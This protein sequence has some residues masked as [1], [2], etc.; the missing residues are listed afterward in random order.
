[1]S[2]ESL[3]LYTPRVNE[4][5]ELVSLDKI[6]LGGLWTLDNY[7]RELQSPNSHFLVLSTNSVGAIIGCGCFWRILEEAHITLLMINPSYQSQGLG[8]LLLYSLLKNAV[9]SH[10]EH[11][12]LEVR[13]S[14]KS[15]IGLYEKFG[16]KIA[17]R[18]KKYYKKT[19]EDALIFWKSDLNSP[20]FQQELSSWKKLIN[21]RLINS[22]YLPPDL[23]CY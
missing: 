6:C 15:A 7:E 12:T 22:C 5:D 1:M 8:Q 2:Y 19:G 17:G 3:K 20:V 9:S 14:N 21:K 18:R 11:A 10:L 13:A 16:F 23:I 4:I